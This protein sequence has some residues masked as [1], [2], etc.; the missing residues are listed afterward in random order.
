MEMTDDER[1]A[2][3]EKT[4]SS[5]TPTEKSEFDDV[6]KKMEATILRSF[7]MKEVWFQ[8][9]RMQWRGVAKISTDEWG[10]RVRF[11]NENHRTLFLSGRW[12]VIIA[13]SNHLGALYCGWIISSECLYPEWESASVEEE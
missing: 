8:E 9:G 2:F 13:S 3:Y 12:D 7:H 4:R 5:L 1:E 6:R 10:V 11:E